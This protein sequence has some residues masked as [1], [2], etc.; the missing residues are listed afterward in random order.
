MPSTGWPY[1]LETSFPNLNTFFQDG[2]VDEGEDGSE[3]R[4]GICSL[5]GRH[6]QTSSK[7]GKRIEIQDGEGSRGNS[8]FAFQLVPWRCF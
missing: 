8:Y 1:F 2:E 5:S 6:S 3:R 7:E 4:P